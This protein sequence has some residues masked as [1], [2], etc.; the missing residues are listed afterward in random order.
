M[1]IYKAF[2][3]YL[4]MLILLIQIGETHER[5]QQIAFNR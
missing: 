3:G 2:L 5:Y 1:G 4:Y